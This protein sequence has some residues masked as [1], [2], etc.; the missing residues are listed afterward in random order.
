MQYK[1]PSNYDEFTLLIR[2]KT[3]KPEKIRVIVREQ[4]KNNTVFTNRFKTVSGE[5]SFF[6][7]L[8]VTGKTLI[9][10]IY[11]ERIGNTDNDNTFEVVEIKRIPLEKKVDAIDFDYN[12]KT[13][14]GFCTKFCYNAGTLDVGTYKGG[15]YTIQYMQTI[16]NNAGKELTTPARIGV[17]SGV[18]QVSRAKF[19]PMTVP[20]RM[21]IML[22]EYSHFFVNDDMSN[23][24]EADLNALLIY[25]GLGYPR[26]EAFE[27]FL[28]TFENA[29]TE[30]NKKRYQK[31]SNFINDFEKH[32]FIVKE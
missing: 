5:I 32:N 6:V 16:K 20:M 24:I 17:E 9:A 2:V 19:L 26:I 12:L 7:R 30:Q 29:P 18:I 10:S 13:F 3:S 27:A 11:N 21:A 31:I 15:K 25:L 4:D 8:P 1:I 22:H 28:K 14:V 23:E